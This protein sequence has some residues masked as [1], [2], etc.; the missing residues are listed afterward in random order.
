MHG[1]FHGHQRF[2]KDTVPL[3]VDKTLYEVQNDEIFSVC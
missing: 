3:I 1:K 2:L